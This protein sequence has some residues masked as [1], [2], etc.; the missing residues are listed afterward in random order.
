[1]FSNASSN[2]E[3]DYKVPPFKLYIPTYQNSLPQR[4][5]Y[6]HAISWK[7]Q[8]KQN[9]FIN[10]LST[11]TDLFLLVQFCLTITPPFKNQTYSGIRPKKQLP[12]YKAAA[13]IRHTITLRFKLLITGLH[14]LFKY[15]WS[16]DQN[17]FTTADHIHRLIAFRPTF[18]KKTFP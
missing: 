9:K 5:L 17:V 14:C 12:K 7:F 13:N 16:M 8:S 3:F 2:Y 4:L 6:T 1:M 10:L 18:I 15:V 11:S